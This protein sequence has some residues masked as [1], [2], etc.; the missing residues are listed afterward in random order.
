MYF[1]FGKK[2]KYLYLFFFLLYLWRKTNSIKVVKG[3]DL[4]RQRLKHAGSSE[5]Y[6]L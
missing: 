5:F 6:S 2:Y 3:G 1:P 4:E